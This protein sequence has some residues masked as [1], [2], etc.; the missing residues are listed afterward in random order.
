[1]REKMGVKLNLYLSAISVVTAGY[2]LVQSP[3][4]KRQFVILPADLYFVPNRK[5]LIFKLKFDYL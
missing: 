5:R 4:S 3:I 1:M 2:D